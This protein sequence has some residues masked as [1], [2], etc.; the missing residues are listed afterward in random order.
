VFTTAKASDIR[1]DQNIGSSGKQEIKLT[2]LFGTH[3]WHHV[4]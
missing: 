4:K 1:D 2:A 3:S